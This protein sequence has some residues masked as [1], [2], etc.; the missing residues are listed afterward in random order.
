MKWGL[1]FVI[2]IKHVGWFTSN[3]YIIVTTYY[4]TKWVEAKVFRTNTMIVI[5]KK[6]YEYIL[7]KF[8]YP[9]TLVTIEIVHFI[10]DAIKYLTNHFFLT[11]LV[12]P[13]VI[14]RE[15]GRQ[16]QPISLLLTSILS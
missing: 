4:A 8:G 2:L 14:H 7:T 3:K 6:L 10:N 16:S 1:D 5:T 13:L 11:T 12:L 9:L 15:M